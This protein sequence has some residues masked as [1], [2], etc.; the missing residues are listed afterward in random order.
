M[1]QG[2]WSVVRSPT[3]TAG[4]GFQP[5]LQP[6]CV[7]LVCDCDKGHSGATCQT[8]S[9]G[10]GGGCGA[11]IRPLSGSTCMVIHSIILLVFNS[12]KARKATLTSSKSITG[13][14]EMLWTDKGQEVAECL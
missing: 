7:C 6:H 9:G 1:L 10:G 14:V 4:L 5:M 13:P 8:K 2:Q 11:H 12:V 3:E